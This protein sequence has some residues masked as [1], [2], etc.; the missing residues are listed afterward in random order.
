MNKMITA[1]IFALATG[2]TTT[3]VLAHDSCNIELESGIKISKQSI[4]FLDDANTP[5]YKIID[6]ETLIINGKTIE[7]TA[8]QQSTVTQYS[9]S[10]RAVVPEVKDIALDAIELA[11]DG[12]N[13][14]F[15]E[16]LG[17]GNNVGAEITAEL[18]I[19]HQQVETHFTAEDGFYI[20]KNGI[21]RDEVFGEDFEQRIESVLE[22]AIK[23]SMG[24]LLMAVGQQMLSSGGDMDGF[25]T[26]MEDFGHKIEHE[27]ETRAK[28]FEKRGELIC[29]SVVA[30]DQLE[31]E[32]QQSISALANIN[33]ISAS[34]ST[35]EHSSHNDEI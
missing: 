2:F 30:I 18:A 28:E 27:M 35:S 20:G 33:V 6:N 9:T 4:E 23:N 29:A 11:S 12:V 19:I 10:I 15:N 25:E 14:A 5:L 8:S 24:S 32:L 26:R 31:T 17:D 13:M 7:L 3:S 34:Q 16:L 1:S 21:E 22:N